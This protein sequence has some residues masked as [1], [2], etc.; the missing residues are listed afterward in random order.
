MP[1]RRVSEMHQRLFFSLIE[2]T[3]SSACLLEGCLCL[4]GDG[5]QCLQGGTWQAGNEFGIPESLVIAAIAQELSSVFEEELHI[6]FGDLGVLGQAGPI[7][8]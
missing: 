7:S 5:G 8:T 1:L 3:S 6:L 2:A 4:W